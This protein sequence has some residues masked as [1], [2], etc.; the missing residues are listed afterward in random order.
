MCAWAWRSSC[1]SVRPFG[2]PRSPNWKRNKRLARG[3]SFLS[4]R[5]HHGSHHFTSHHLHIRSR[6]GEHALI[7]QRRCINLISLRASLDERRRTSMHYKLCLLAALALTALGAI[8]PVAAQGPRGEPGECDGF[9]YW[10]DGECMDARQKKN[11]K[12]WQQEI[13]EKQWKP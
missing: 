11:G 5:C 4:L 7:L 10:H 6:S 2:R 9:K 1:A 3:A 8:A 13:L 12:T